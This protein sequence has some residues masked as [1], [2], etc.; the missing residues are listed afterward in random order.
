MYLAPFGMVVLLIKILFRN[1]CWFGSIGA[2]EDW[3]GRLEARKKL[4]TLPPFPGGRTLNLVGLVGNPSSRDPWDSVSRG[5]CPP[6]ATFGQR[7]RPIWPKFGLRPLPLAGSSSCSSVDPLL[8]LPW[9]TE[10]VCG[11]KLL[12]G[13]GRNPSPMT[14]L[15][16]GQSVRL[17]DLKDEYQLCEETCTQL[18]RPFVSN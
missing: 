14:C 12:S 4:F 5:F 10:E 9:S 7:R 8:L 17:K 18:E 2:E 1:F 11:P 16:F 3:R 15:L 6:R 13:W